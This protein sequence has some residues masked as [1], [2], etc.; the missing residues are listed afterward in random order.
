MLGGPILRRVDASRV[1]VWLATSKKVRIRGG[2][3]RQQRR[4]PIGTVVSGYLGEGEAKTVELGQRLFVHLIEMEPDEAGTLPTGEVLAYEL[5][6]T[7]MKGNIVPEVTEETKRMG[8]ALADGQELANPTFIIQSSRQDFRAVYAS[9]RK[10]HGTGPDAVSGIL[11]MLAK[12]GLDEDRRPLVLLLTGDQIYADDVSD[13][14]IVHLATLSKVLTGELED[15]PGIPDLP[16]DTVRGRGDLVRR[17]AQ[18]T[19]GHADN[20]LLRF[21]EF[22]ALYLMSWNNALWPSEL[23]SLLEIYK[24]LGQRPGLGALGGTGDVLAEEYREQLEALEQSQ[25]STPKLRKIMANTPTYMIFDDHEITDDWNLNEKWRSEVY[26]SE[27][28]VRI[29]ANGLA[30]YW[31]F[32]GWGNNPD[33]FDDT[34]TTAIEDFLGGTAGSPNGYEQTLLEWDE[35]GFTSPTHPGIVFID[36]RTQRAPSTTR[37][38]IHNGHSAPRPPG[39]NKSIDE[40]PPRLL[41]RGAYQTLRRE[42]GRHATR[43]NPLVL[44]TPSPVLGEHILE[45]LQNVLG[46]VHGSERW[47]LEAWSSNPRNLIHMFELIE[48]SGMPVNIVL[49]GDVH[50]TF[51]ALGTVTTSKSLLQFTSSPSKNI[52]YPDSIR[53]IVR[54]YKKLHSSITTWW[55]AQGDVGPIESHDTST[56]RLHKLATGR[57]QQI[58]SPSYVT[59]TTYF[60]KRNGDPVFTHKNNFGY[61][62]LWSIKHGRNQFWNVDDDGNLRLSS[63]QEWDLR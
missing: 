9:C 5:T 19:S 36:T 43:L 53:A 24:A 50:C 25:H 49:S 45:K 16:V 58:G 15:V 33:V 14:L 38:D 27:S 2:V 12:Y 54:Y 23:P 30:A 13:L 41:D 1:I 8:L 55:W 11:S 61:L 29:V 20:H 26:S 31:A 42:I 56:S 39:R 3:F 37:A 57:A 6:A 44:V 18:F 4:R 10:L 21:G 22:A 52:S 28:G 51:A 46:V 35:W 60:S 62:A 59:S 32:Q 17:Y 63:Q 48:N 34:F 7:D 47:D 40:F